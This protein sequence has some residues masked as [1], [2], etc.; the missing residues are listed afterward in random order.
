M[1]KSITFGERL[2]QLREEKKL[3]QEQ[4]GELLNFSKANISRYENNI[5]QPSF[6][7]LDFFCDFFDVSINYILGKTNVRKNIDI[8]I[9]GLNKINP[10]DLELLI[11]FFSKPEN[12]GYLALSIE[13]KEHGI[14]VETLLA[15]VKGYQSGSNK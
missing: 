5:H 10:S 9:V 14:P 3:S 4:L 2:R 11:N 13:A 1:V 8:D 15:F 12:K 7:V 6:E